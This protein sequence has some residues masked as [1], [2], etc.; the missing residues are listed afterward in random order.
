LNLS[1]TVDDRGIRHIVTR[2]VNTIQLT[3]KLTLG[4]KNI[5]ALEYL[6][7]SYDLESK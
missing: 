7:T 1:I 5:R 3:Y 2:V 4:G 6:I